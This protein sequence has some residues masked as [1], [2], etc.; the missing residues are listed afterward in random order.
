MLGFSVVAITLLAQCSAMGH[1]Y[2]C[3]ADEALRLFELRTS[4]EG[5]KGR[6][7]HLAM[8]SD[9]T[10]SVKAVHKLLI[11]IQSELDGARRTASHDPSSRSSG[12]GRHVDIVA[13]LGQ[14]LQIAAQLLQNAKGC[15]N[16]K[17]MPGINRK[18]NSSGDN[19]T[20][21]SNNKNN[22]SKS[23]NTSVPNSAQPSSCPAPAPELL[24]GDTLS[25]LSSVLRTYPRGPTSRQALA[26]WTAAATAFLQDHQRRQR[27]Q[28][29][30]AVDHH[31]AMVAEDRVEDAE[32]EPDVEV[33]EVRD[34]DGLEEWSGKAFGR[35]KRRLARRSDVIR[36]GENQSELPIRR[37]LASGTHLK[38][39]EV[40]NRTG[41]DNGGDGGSRGGPGCEGGSR[42]VSSVALGEDKYTYGTDDDDGD[43][44]D[45]GDGDGE[46]KGGANDGTQYCGGLPF[47]RRVLMS[48]LLLGWLSDLH[49][50][51]LGTEQVAVEMSRIVALA[52]DIH[53][54]SVSQRAIMEFFHISKAGGTSWY[55]AATG[56]PRAAQ[57]HKTAARANGYRY[58]ANEYTLLGGTD[59]MYGTHICPEFVNV[60]NIRE[61]LERLASN[62]K[63]MLVR[64]RSELFQKGKSL[65]IFSK[66]FCNASA[67]VWEL[68]STPVADNYNIRTLVHVWSSELLVRQS[69][70][71]LN[72]CQ[73]GNLTELF[74]RQ[75][76]DKRWYSF[77]RTLSHLDQLFLSTAAH[78]GLK[79][80]PQDWEEK[81]PPART[82]TGKPQ[83]NEV[84]KPDRQLMNE[85]ANTKAKLQTKGEDEG[86]GRGQPSQRKGISIKSSIK[87]STRNTQHIERGTGSNALHRH[88]L[89]T[90]R[91]SGWAG[92]F[93]RRTYQL[94]LYISQLGW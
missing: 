76:Y 27:Q 15:N 28:R 45:G 88:S 2:L 56:G 57:R 74:A 94:A 3:P 65:E 79:P 69:G 51:M 77:G 6:T 62:I 31:A 12:D 82:S 54:E 83:K 64:L 58:I 9:S 39:L 30:A 81:A 1:K 68:Y 43:R 92:A 5:A 50:E 66:I 20:G 40:G 4:L 90:A 10:E 19:S 71:D 14:I 80:W 18:D 85:K 75:V 7:L 24:Q 38:A 91:C 73:V 21:N 25:F 37:R 47:V 44:T 55:T 67:S 16:N 48:Q 22:N 8:S 26:N 17:E 59:D 52:Y 78:M 72:E 33:E 34:G 49:Q 70:L 29:P 60:I 89:W 32:E 63:Y 46:V 36:R 11:L 35:E 84:R 87:S 41:G 86:E 13:H 23:W 61:P 53:V 93:V 42:R